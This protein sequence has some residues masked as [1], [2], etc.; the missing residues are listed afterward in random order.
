MAQPPPA[1]RSR[2]A[3]GCSSGGGVVNTGST[4]SNRNLAQHQ[5]T[6]D[7]SCLYQYGTVTLHIPDRL[8][9]GHYSS[10]TW[11][12][13]RTLANFIGSGQLRNF[14]ALRRHHQDRQQQRRRGNGDDSKETKV[15]DTVATLDAAAIKVAA[16]TAA[17]SAAC[18]SSS[19]S[20]S[21]SSNSSS[22]TIGLDYDSIASQNSK[23]RETTYEGLCVIE[24]GAGTGLPGL[25]LAA[26]GASVVLTDQSGQEGDLAREAC[27]SVAKANGIASRVQVTPLDWGLFT[28]ELQ[29]LPSA[30]VVLASDCMY[31]TRAECADFLATVRLLLERGKPGAICLCAYQI[32]SANRVLTPWFDDWGMVATKVTTLRTARTI[33]TSS[34]KTTT[35]IDDGIV[36]EKDHHHS[37][38]VIALRLCAAAT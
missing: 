11:P 20:N 12:C 14:L 26:L 37:V 18:S 28:P 30:D 10:Y 38:E 21:N 4:C 32:R 22:D 29:S 1:K 5:V 15:S 33:T 7:E 25:L 31:G 9:G 2:D 36:G 17:S 3:T 35:I 24:L 8:V 23:N 13:A 34:T 6:A 19:S 16:V 27:R